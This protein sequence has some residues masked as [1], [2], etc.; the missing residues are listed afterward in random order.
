MSAA[1]VSSAE[2]MSPTSTAPP[3]A[4]VGATAPSSPAAST[5]AG[6]DKMTDSMTSPT[7]ASP[8]MQEPTGT[9]ITTAPSEFGDILFDGGGQAIYLFDK[10]TG[11]TAECYDD[12]AADWPPVLTSGQPAAEGGIV[13][14][15][16]GT[17]TR[18]DGS[19]QVTYG[20]HPLSFHEH[21]EPTEVNCHDVDEYGGTW[22]VVTPSGQA[23]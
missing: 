20:D 15:L 12:C 4:S 17:T 13:A 5:P 18:A 21:K 8:S 23:A 19:V 22:L 10:E 16:L 14:D 7:P 2:P 9:V 1:A 6:A 11:T 3:A